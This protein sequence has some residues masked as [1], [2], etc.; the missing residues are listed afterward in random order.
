MA[1]LFI[2][3]I[4]GY[5]GNWFFAFIFEALAGKI[6]F[7]VDPSYSLISAH[8]QRVSQVTAVNKSALIQHLYQTKLHQLSEYIQNRLDS[9]NKN[10][11]HNQKCANS[12]RCVLPTGIIY[13]FRN[14]ERLL[15]I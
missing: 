15:I 3:L 4:L 14:H 7:E 2:V 1:G 12:I 10:I 9:V 5:H 6:T 11:F 13:C 8:L